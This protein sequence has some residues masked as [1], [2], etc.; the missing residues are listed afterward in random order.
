MI[1]LAAKLVGSVKSTQVCLAIA[2]LQAHGETA[3]D[4]LQ[5][6]PLKIHLDNPFGR[7]LLTP[8]IGLVVIAVSG[9]GSRAIMFFTFVVAVSPVENLRAADRTL[10]PA[11]PAKT[12]LLA[13][14]QNLG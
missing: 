9:Q 1:C 4:F 7:K 5:P 13:Q 6:R 8:A 11:R 12:P 10:G 14:E 2:F 3:P